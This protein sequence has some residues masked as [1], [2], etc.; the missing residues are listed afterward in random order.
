MTKLVS[1]IDEVLT[2][3]RSVRFRMNFDRA[4]DPSIIEEC[5]RLAQPATMG[6][7][8]E[9][10]R[11]V[12]MTSPE[13]KAR[14]AEVY[15]HV[16]LKTVEEPLA[17]GEA[18]TVE[19]L[20]PSVRL[21]Q[22]AKGRQERTLSSVKYLVDNLERVPV[23]VFACSAKPVPDEAMG[24]KASEYYGSIF[25][26]VWSFQLACRSRGLGTV[27]A[28]AIVYESEELAKILQLP[29]GTYPITMIPVGYTKGLDFRPAKRLPLKEILRWERWENS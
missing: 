10:W 9:D 7:N 24:G 28:T 2:T 23:L 21:T 16:W 15:R 3:T 5:L 17:V 22:D 1:D 18:D 6:S 29:D 8:L 25:P 14:V 4:V 19:I 11:F 20:S 26:I 27:T 13:Q 12:A